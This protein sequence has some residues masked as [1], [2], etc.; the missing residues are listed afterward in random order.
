MMPDIHASS[1]LPHAVPST[2]AAVGEIR[3]TQNSSTGPSSFGRAP[4]I[5]EGREHYL[6]RIAWSN[7]D[8]AGCVNCIAALD[9]WKY[10]NCEGKYRL[11]TLANLP[12]LLP[13]NDQILEVEKNVTGWLHQ[14]AAF[15]PLS[16]Q[17]SSGRIEGGI[18]LI[19]CERENHRPS[20]TMSR[21]VYEKVE[22]QFELHPTT[23]PALFMHGGLYVKYLERDSATDQ[24]TKLRI[25]VKAAQKVEV[26]NYLLSLTYDFSTRWTTAII[27]GDGVV[28]ARPRDSPYGQQL[29]QLVN[30]IS[31]NPSLWTDPLFLPSVLLHNYA[32]R[33]QIRADVTDEDV[34]DVEG[35][36]GVMSA[37]RTFAERDIVNWPSDIDPKATAIR[38]HS[39][40]PQIIFMRSSCKWLQGYL[41]FLRAAVNELDSG[42][43]GATD[44]RD[45]NRNISESLEYASSWID[46]IETIFNSLQER[47]ELQANVLFS[48]ISQQENL[49]N[50]KESQINTSI[51]KS[52]KNDS[53]SMTTFTFITALFLPGSFLATLFSMSMFNWQQQ[54]STDD[55]AVLSNK[56]WLYWAIAV[57]LTL[58]TMLGWCL[59]YLHASKQFRLE[60]EKTRVDDQ[61][62]D[63]M[64]TEALWVDGRRMT[65][66]GSISYG[67]H[68][69][70]RVSLHGGSP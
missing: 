28:S 31:I 36:L 10:D 61:Q 40:A 16:N 56:F 24:P 4:L 63:K 55:V 65:P 38:L 49:L 43:P 58:C 44:F 19:M 12:C 18:R 35:M 51:A 8:R 7:E 11:T 41:T 62:D 20:M 21:Q 60:L 68:T 2:A 48:V 25:V 14:T 27:C 57:P 13:P 22:Q 30:A 70:A 42:K 17:Q 53:I 37:G 15:E 5:P 3:S 1:P 6:D 66:P 39:V 59:W 64:A 50:Q 45:S 29:Q 69:S 67:R 33:T 26:A 47:M 9:C 46:G 23:L 32:Y 52:A 54:N 34:R